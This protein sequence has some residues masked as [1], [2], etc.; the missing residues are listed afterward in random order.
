MVPKSHIHNEESLKNKE[1]SS[2]EFEIQRSLE[3]LK[4]EIRRYKDRQNEIE[5][6][7]EYDAEGRQSSR[8]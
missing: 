3:K 8:T 6:S 7:G 4:Q 5:C 1:M 2:E